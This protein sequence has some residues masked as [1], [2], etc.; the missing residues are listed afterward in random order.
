MTLFASWKFNGKFNV[1]S[2]WP[3]FKINYNKLPVVH[4]AAKFQICQ[5]HG[6][7]HSSLRSSR[8]ERV[9]PKGMSAWEAMFSYN[10]P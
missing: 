4:V 8:G 10:E 3:Y 6:S 7:V 1:I 5:A 2:I 9:E